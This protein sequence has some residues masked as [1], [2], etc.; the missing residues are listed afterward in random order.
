MRDTVFREDSV[1][2]VT[3]VVGDHLDLVPQGFERYGQTRQLPF[4][5]SHLQMT[6]QADDFHA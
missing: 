3:A 2:E 6:C 1:E 5:P 4:Q